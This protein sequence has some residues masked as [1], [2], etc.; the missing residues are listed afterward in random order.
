MVEL[1]NRVSALVR[2][3]L[4][5]RAIE[6]AATAIRHRHPD[7]PWLATLRPEDIA[8]EHLIDLVM[9]LEAWCAE[10]PPLPVHPDSHLAR[11]GNLHVELKG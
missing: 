7:A 2:L 5:E 10:Q 8:A 9:G 3:D 11:Q 6:L 1:A 4:C